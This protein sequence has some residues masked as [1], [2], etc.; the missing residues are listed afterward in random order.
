MMPKAN[1]KKQEKASLSSRVTDMMIHILSNVFRHLPDLP[2]R[3]KGF[4]DLL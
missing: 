4:R 2:Y 3:L 1:S